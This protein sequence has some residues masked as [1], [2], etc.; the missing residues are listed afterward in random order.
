[1]VFKLEIRPLAKNDLFE[2]V[3]WYKTIG[4][5]LSIQ[6]LNEV[7]FFLNL[8]CENPNL[9]QSAGRQCRRANLS[10]FPYKIIYKVEDE[11][12]VVIALLHHKRRPGSWKK[13]I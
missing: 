6:F 1:M 12:V 3:E 5:V 13:R 11:I 2:V 4:D 10:K 9:F 7:Q 8:I